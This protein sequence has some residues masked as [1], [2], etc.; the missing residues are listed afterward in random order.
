MA[1]PTSVVQSASERKAAEAQIKALIKRYSPHDEKLVDSLRK[2]FRK[3]MPTSH[4]VA[5]EYSN[6]V[7]MSFSPSEKG[8][9]GILVIHAGGEGVRLY[10]NRGKELPDPEKL[11]Q[12]S[13]G[14][15][16]WIPIESIAAIKRPEVAALI[17]AALEQ[18]PVPFAD[19]G[20]GSV[21]VRPTA[22]G[23]R[24]ETKTPKPKSVGKKK[25]G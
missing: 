19:S 20:T 11:L 21:L 16:R 22:A 24:R 14:I 10:F 18:N 12:G 3:R 1:K 9:E 7:V 17:D 2:A 8:Y 23:K 15:A 13:G 25:S 4:E 6:A 5:Y